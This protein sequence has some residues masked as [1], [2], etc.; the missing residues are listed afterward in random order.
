MK[1][2]SNFEFKWY[3]NE[4]LIN[5]NNNN[6]DDDDDV[7]VDD[8]SHSNYFEQSRLDEPYGSKLAFKLTADQLN[9]Y[10]TCS[11]DFTDYYSMKIISR[12]VSVIF[13]T[14]CK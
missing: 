7:G 1:A 14:K 11:L 5:N 13:R 9:G 3:R 10:Y 4:Q 8:K 2:S 12:N 6:N